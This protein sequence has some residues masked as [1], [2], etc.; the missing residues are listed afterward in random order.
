TVRYLVADTARIAAYHSIQALP[1]TV[2]VSGAVNEFS[3][4]FLRLGQR[5]LLLFLA[6]AGLVTLVFS[7]LLRRTTRSLE[8]LTVATA[9]VGE[10]NFAPEL[11]PAGR[12]EVGR[13]TA[14]FGTMVDKVR[15]TVAE[16][17]AS[18]QMAVLGEFA[19]HLSHEVRNP[20]TSIKLNLQK[21]ERDR[22]EGRLPDSAAIP[23]GI[24]LR[25]SARLDEVVRGVLD[26]TRSAPTRRELGSLNAVIAEAI[27]VVTPQAEASGVRIERHL[28]AMADRVMLDHS[29]VKGAILNVCLNAI[30]AMPSGGTL[31]VRTTSAGG[32]ITVAIGDTGPG[33]P[34]ELRDRIF[35]PFFTRRDG[36]TGLGLPLAK[37]AVEESGGTL[38]LSPR[39]G[40]GAEFIL[41][42]PAGGPA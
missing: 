29:A 26:L 23:L 8:E 21:L 37:R 20:L 33:V 5:T 17:Q 38:S 15:E 12:D 34:E 3:A 39:P 18:R 2:V 6:V 22:R 9:V 40:P 30:M 36:G 42:F 32:A 7:Q 10:G 14:S 28:D 19:A 4:P 13:L 31:T 1:W 24:A 27:E 41:T 35:Q 16:I 11:P 25:E